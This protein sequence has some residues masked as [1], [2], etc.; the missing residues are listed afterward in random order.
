MRICMILEGCYPYVRGGVSSW[1]HQYIQSMPQHEFVLW[2][3]GAYEKDRG[4]FKY[5]LPSNVVLVKEVFLDASKHLSAKKNR[6]FSF[7]QKE[8][9]AIQDLLACEEPDWDILFSCYHDMKKNP[10]SFFMSTQFLSI[11]RDIC[12]NKYPTAAYADTFFTMRSMFLTVITLLSEEIPT[13]DIYHSTAAGYGG[14][15]GAL[16][17]WKTKKPF[18]LTEHGIYTREREEEILRASWVLKEFKN[19]W[20]RM[21]YMLSK[22]AY[23]YADGVSSLFNK[24]REIQIEIG[25]DPSKTHVIGNGILLQNFV[26]IPMKPKDGWIDIGAIVR[27]APIKDIKTMIYAFY[28]AKQKNPMM[29]LHILGGIDSE[30]YHQECLDLIQQLGIKDILIVGNTDVRAYMAKLDFTILTSISEG[31]PLSVLE[32]F[33]AARPVVATEVGCCKELIEGE[34]DGLGDAGICCAPMHHE[35]IAK[36][37]LKL[38]QEEDL[39]KSMGQN[40]QK[41]VVAHFSH[42]KMLAAYQKIYEEMISSYGRHRI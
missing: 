37:I 2:T 18:F 14:V 15:L 40:A 11:V 36:A 21:F 30:E 19:M 20:I 3:I 34:G 8:R 23:E 27:F 10:A 31:Q 25:C 24:A 29:R 17:K 39:R 13:A 33:G 9:K 32:S 5:E 6:L 7:N 26:D 28:L 1:M 38:S 42:Q 4:N 22:C 35:D 12:E 41:R 16:A